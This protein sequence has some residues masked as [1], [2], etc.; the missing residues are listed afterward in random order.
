MTLFSETHITQKYLRLYGPDTARARS[1]LGKLVHIRTE[2]GVWNRDGYDYTLIERGDAWVLPFEEA[3]KLTSHCGPE[4]RAVF[5]LADVPEKPTTTRAD[6]R[7]R[8]LRSG[9]NYDVL[10]P[11]NLDRLGELIVEHCAD[12]GAMRGSV[13][14][15]G[16]AVTSKSGVGYYAGLRCESNYFKDREAITFNADGFIGFAGWADDENIVPFLSAFC[17]WV[18]E[19]EDAA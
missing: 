10:S 11:K 13:E 6:A 14:I 2:N 12:V 16:E 1:W 4:K 19:L 17:E 3:V 8:F 5:I 18:V 15:D 9:L 7:D